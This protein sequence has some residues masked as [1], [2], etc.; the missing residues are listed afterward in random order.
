MD[1]FNSF[2]FSKEQ[3]AK[4]AIAKRIAGEAFACMSMQNHSQWNTDGFY[5]PRSIA[6]LLLSGIPLAQEDVYFPVPADCPYWARAVLAGDLVARPFFRR[7][8]FDLD[9]AGKA[10]VVTFFVIEAA[11]SNWLDQFN[12]RLG[13]ETLKLSRVMATDSGTQLSWSVP[14]GNQAEMDR[15]SMDCPIV[16]SSDKWGRFSLVVT[17]PHWV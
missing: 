2:I 6:E 10:G 17:K 4:E 1:N 9:H 16:G 8:W 12:C 11:E 3:E 5:A 14:E 7:A 13:A 15:L